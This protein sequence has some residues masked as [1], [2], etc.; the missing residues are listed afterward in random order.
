M[1]FDT[2]SLRYDD[3]PRL[4]RAKLELEASLAIMPQR[5]QSVF[6]L[7]LVHLRLGDSRKARELLLKAIDLEPKLR[8]RLYPIPA[9][10]QLLDGV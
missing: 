6:Y 10:R 7:A 4:A 8:D 3:G 2:A 5:A 1:L 9:V